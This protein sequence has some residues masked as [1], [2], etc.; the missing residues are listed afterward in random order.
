MGL[1]AIDLFT[2]CG[3]MNMQ[4]DGGDCSDTSMKGVLHMDD[5]VTL[6]VL[7]IVLEIIKSIKK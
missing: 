6:I 7:I 2:I 4:R 3:I 5:I 1:I